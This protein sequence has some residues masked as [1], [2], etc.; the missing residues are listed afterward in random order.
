MMD[1]ELTERKLGVVKNGEGIELKMT[2][3][4][5]RVIKF[6]QKRKKEIIITTNGNMQKLKKK[7]NL[8]NLN[9][10]V[11]LG[12]T[13]VEKNYKSIILWSAVTSEPLVSFQLN[14]KLAWQ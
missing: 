7:I 12:E 5:S 11:G 3:I 8:L 10:T 14:L 13:D 2:F 6:E 1:E 9:E 4:V